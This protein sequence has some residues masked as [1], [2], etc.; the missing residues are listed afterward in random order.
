[1][2]TVVDGPLA[3]VVALTTASLGVAVSDVV[4]DSLVVHGDLQCGMCPPPTGGGV[5]FTRPLR[6]P[7]PPVHPLRFVQRI[8]SSRALPQRAP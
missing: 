4:V 5:R 1:M 8:P 2:A 3:A 7:P 6:P